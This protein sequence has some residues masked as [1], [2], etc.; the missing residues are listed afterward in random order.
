MKNYYISFGQEHKHVINGKVLDKDCLALI[1][2][3]SNVEMR[4]KAFHLY[5]GEK[6]AFSYEEQSL[7]EIIK[8]FP[9]GVIEF[10]NAVK[11]IKL[12]ND[13]DRQ[14]ETHPTVTRRSEMD[15]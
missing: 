14:E 9:R 4:N 1:R 11:R 5:F 10:E 3:N 13:E 12:L 7:N 2:A 8:H 15:Q 6:F